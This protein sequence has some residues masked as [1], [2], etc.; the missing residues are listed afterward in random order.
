MAKADT[1][2]QAQPEPSDGMSL[3]QQ[4]LV[5]VLVAVVGAVATAFATGWAG[6]LFAT[7]KPPGCPGD[8]CEGKDPKAE[9]CTD[10]GAYEPNKGN[11]ARLIIRY[12]RECK[13]VWGKI[14]HGVPGDVVSVKI[15]GGTNH[16][17]KID[18]ENDVFTRMSA[19]GNGAFRVKVCA[20]PVTGKEHRPEWSSYCIDATDATD[21][22]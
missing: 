22:G 1:D 19:V 14:A 18:Y 3:W 10:A 2:W 7:Q 9:G 17:A 6:E 13:A 12:S 4:I 15:E 20:Y 21:W 8:A 5:G 16:R 11:P